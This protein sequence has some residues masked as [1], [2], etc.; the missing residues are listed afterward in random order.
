MSLEKSGNLKD[1]LEKYKK[2]LAINNDIGIPFYGW[3]NMGNIYKKLEYYADAVNCYKKMIPHL[4]SRNDEQGLHYCHY[5]IMYCKSMMGDFDREFISLAESE[6]NGSDPI[7]RYGAYDMLSR[8]YRDKVNDLDEA[9]RYGVKQLELAIMLLGRSFITYKNLSTICANLAMVVS[10]HKLYKYKETESFYLRKSIDIC[11]KYNDYPFNYKA[12][13]D[14]LWK[15]D[16]IVQDVPQHTV[17][18]G[19]VAELLSRII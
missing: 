17:Y 19:K 12:I 7:G 14:R 4:E 11:R 8:Y 10:A 5:Y 2:A 16:R 3:I 9:E 13:L 1:A 18:E 6:A 15:L